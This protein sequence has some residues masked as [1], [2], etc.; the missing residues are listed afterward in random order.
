MVVSRRIDLRGLSSFHR[1]IGT[2][3]ARL[4][5]PGIYWVAD[6]GGHGLSHRDFVLDGPS[7]S[8]YYR[9]YEFDFGPGVS[10]PEL[11]IRARVELRR[12]RLN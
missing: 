8:Q 10:I 2:R 6:H 11:G 5:E 9:L 3:L 4:S 12:L 7:C 1:G